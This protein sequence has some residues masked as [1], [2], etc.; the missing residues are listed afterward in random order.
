MVG[1]HSRQIKTQICAVRG[2]RHP[3]AMNF[4]HYQSP[5]LLGSSPPI[6]SKYVIHNR[7]NLEQTS[8]AYLIYR[9]NLG[10]SEKNK[11]PDRLGFSRHMKTRL[12]LT[13]LFCPSDNCLPACLSVC[14]SVCP[15][16]SLCLSVCLCV[17]VSV[18][19]CLSV[20]QSLSA[21]LSVYFIHMA[22]ISLFR[23]SQSVHSL[24]FLS[25]IIY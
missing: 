16:L 5:K 11:I 3:S 9:Q 7:E 21:S 18:L 8:G 10:W 25:L 6:I 23:S 19:V 2:H 17:C 14:L 13:D 12:Y 24:L 22:P 4:A 15:S 1:D 20:C